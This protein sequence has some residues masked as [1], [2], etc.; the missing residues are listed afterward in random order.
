M[1]TGTVWGIALLLAGFAAVLIGFQLFLAA[2]FPRRLDRSREALLRWP[3]GAVPLGLVV[4]VAVLVAI[5]ALAQWKG[6]GQFLSAVVAI[7]GTTFA[8]FGLAVV[9]REVGERMPSPASTPWR[10]LLRGAVTT[11]LAA[12]VPIVGWLFLFPFS[13]S[14]GLGGL[15]LSGAVATERDA[16]AAEPAGSATAPPRDPSEPPAIDRVREGAPA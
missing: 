12:N 14:A 2:L 13:I 16:A 8:A 4:L 7:A 9:S 6:P 11:M 1:L 10:A 15:L 5:A 3:W